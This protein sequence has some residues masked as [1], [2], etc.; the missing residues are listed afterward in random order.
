MMRP[1]RVISLD[2]C[3]GG[4]EYQVKTGLRDLEICDLEKLPKKKGAGARV[5]NIVYQLYVS[6][7]E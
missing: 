5:R 3:E 4:V 2:Y 6:L 1:L 7:S